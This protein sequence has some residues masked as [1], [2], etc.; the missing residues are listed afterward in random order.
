MA[1]RH[2]SRAAA[3]DGNHLATVVPMT[4]ID[5]S[6][7]ASAVY[8]RFTALEEKAASVYVEFASRFS[9]ENASLS[10][11]WLNMAMDE[12]QH[13]GLLQFCLRE[14]LF[15]EEI[16]DAAEIRKLTDVFRRLEKRAADPKLTVESAFRLA[17]ELE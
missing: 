7:R 14:G 11:F 16:P 5:T 17:I 9:P 4:K 3:E 12:K 10:S 1:R 13:A 6:R 2:L 8:R 15:A